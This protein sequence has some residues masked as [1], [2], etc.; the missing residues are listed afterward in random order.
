MVLFSNSQ[1]GA[2]RGAS[3]RQQKGQIVIPAIGSEDAAAARRAGNPQPGTRA[4]V[5]DFALYL[6]ALLTGFSHRGAL[7]GDDGVRRRPYSDA[8]PAQ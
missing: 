4:L 8:G 3:R 5:V 1:S 7:R 2:A 6:R